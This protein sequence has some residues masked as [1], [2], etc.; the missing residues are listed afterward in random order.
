M[1]D[2]ETIA[3]YTI[4]SEFLG[5]TL[6]EDFEIVLHD[7]KDKKQSIVHIV[8]GHISGRT[9][10]AP[11]TDLALGFIS[12]QTFREHDYVINYKGF[13]KNSRILRS[14]TLFIKDQQGNLTGMLCI[15]FDGSK[16]VSLS[17][18]ILALSSMGFAPEDSAP[19]PS[20]E[21]QDAADTF[22]GSIAEVTDSV[23]SSTLENADVP[24][25]RLTQEE[26]MRVVKILSDKGIFMLKGAVSG[27]A[28]K[29][30][31]SEATL[32]RYIR[33]VSKENK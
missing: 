20:A 12:D 8:N 10:E 9:N 7:I 15:N 19:Q 31:V 5:K 16:Y 26:K 32:Y 25:E 33:L 13:P 28:E 14:S 17:K 18:Q 6:G 2:K 21:A 27:V 22:S 4:L 3:Q 11:L 23:L 30:H 1:M 24:A 29:L